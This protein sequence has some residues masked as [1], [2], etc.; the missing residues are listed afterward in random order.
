MA[1]TFTPAFETGWSIIFTADGAS[2]RLIHFSLQRDSKS[3][4]GLYHRHP[5]GHTGSIRSK[6]PAIR[7]MVDP[8]QLCVEPQT[9]SRKEMPFKTPA[10]FIRIAKLS[11]DL[12]AAAISD[13]LFGNNKIACR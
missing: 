11:E 4:Y 2:I 10:I 9:L 6:C 12:R 13:Q 8:K 3:D 7:S 1:A 5:T